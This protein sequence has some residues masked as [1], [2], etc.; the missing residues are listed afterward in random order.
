MMPGEGEELVSDTPEQMETTQGETMEGYSYRVGARFGGR[1]WITVAAAG[2]S[3]TGPRVPPGLYRAWIAAQV[4]LLVGAAGC[5][6]AAAVLLSWQM[7]VIALGLLVAHFAAG[8]VGAGCLWEMQNLVSFMQGTRGE[9]Q[10]F[11]LDEVQDVRIGAGWARRG[12]WLMLL[13][14]FKGID[15]MARNVCV[16]FVAPNG[17]PGGGVYALHMRTAEEAQRLAGL[18]QARGV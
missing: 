16:S 6:V 2:V 14:Y 15:A 13:P 10:A 9:T 12:M 7:L 4:V 17:T 8:G 18:L 1:V 5:L 11:R 3:V